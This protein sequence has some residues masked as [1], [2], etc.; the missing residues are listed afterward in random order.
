MNNFPGF[1]G[2]SALDMQTNLQLAV[3]SVIKTGSNLPVKLMG[4]SFVCRANWT[5][6]VLL[7]SFLRATTTTDIPTDNTWAMLASTTRKLPRIDPA[8]WVARPDGMLPRWVQLALIGGANHEGLHFRFTRRGAISAEQ[9]KELL[10]PR[11]RLIKNWSVYTSFLRMFH[12]IA[13]DIRIERAGL[14]VMPGMYTELCNLQDFILDMEYKGRIASEGRPLD[15]IPWAYRDI[16]LG[17]TTDKSRVTLDWYENANP[18]AF[19]VVVDGPLTTILKRNIKLTGSNNLGALEC[20]L[21]TCI[22][23][24]QYLDAE[25]NRQFQRP[26]QPPT[27]SGDS[28]DQP[29]SGQGQP[30]QGQPQQGQP[31]K[32]DDNQDP[33]NQ[34][35]QKN[36]NTSSQKPDK[37][38]K[39]Q[40]PNQDKGRG[41]DRQEGQDK[42]S[43]DQGKDGDQDDQEQNGQP[44]KDSKDQ[45]QGNNDQDGQGQDQKDGQ[46]G[47]PE[48]GDQENKDGQNGKPDNKDGQ[49]QGDQEKDGGQDG[50]DGDQDG[51]PGE[52]PGGQGQDQGKPSDQPG[53]QE[54]DGD[55]PGG[56]Q[57]GT[58][59][60]K[61]G[62]QDGK[63]G[64]GGEESNTKLPVQ[65][66]G[67]SPLA[68]KNRGSDA[69]KLVD[70]L[71]DLVESLESGEKSAVRN[72][73]EAMAE[74]LNAE[75]DL[76]QKDIVGQPWRPFTTEHDI[77]KAP[78]DVIDDMSK[79]KVE[80]LLREVH[81]E[82]A[83]LRSRLHQ[84]LRALE[85]TS[86]KHGVK[87]GS[88][89][90][91][92]KLVRSRIQL[93]HKQVPNKPYQRTGEKIDTSVAA[94][95]VL[96]ESGSMRRRLL[97]A[98][99]ALL[100]VVDPLDYIGAATMAIG[101]RDPPFGQEHEAPEYTQLECEQQN[102]LAGFHRFDNTMIDVFKTFDE[103]FREVKGRFVHTTATGMTP[104]SEGI[105]YAMQAL[106]ERTEGH[107]LLIVITDGQPTD[108]EVVRHQLEVAKKAGI[109]LIGV[110]ITEK[111]Q[112]VKTTFY[113]WV[114]C[115]T[116]SELPTQLVDKLNQILDPLAS[117]RGTKI[118][119]VS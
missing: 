17:Y 107:R 9:V 13:E 6:N 63:D 30:Q 112:Y 119:M 57:K 117:K 84:K 2:R 28:Q 60:D 100:A 24:Q 8:V 64:Q 99:K 92:R 86:I 111:A 91:P 40:K 81:Q 76:K 5:A 21:D 115:P 113:D 36:P 26:P 3:N 7:E 22:A 56:D 79:L 108:R 58:P 51:P 11:W 98:T 73:H 68:G 12:N 89:L 87:K 116:L 78:V 14:K 53:D 31:N 101:F 90:S 55:Q 69:Q 43:K 46:D 114:Y 110:G 48:K 97:T 67:G 54:H 25:K 16:G 33:G 75:K 41:Q 34:P 52:T 109:H 80:A 49:D 4:S 70:A 15:I 50:K 18:D 96:D 77:I 39:D 74:V 23:I 95:V 106:S 82:I 103:D 38:Q 35:Q 29:Q 19:R 85:M 61:D 94:A 118:E 37:P 20:A 104:M 1:T 62:G 83:Y 10:E 59:S 102:E 71:N 93:T 45:P 32:D 65:D 47:D 105:Q 66:D 44:N 72:I 27:A 88:R 42:D